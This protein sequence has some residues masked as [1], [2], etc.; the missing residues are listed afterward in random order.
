MSWG[1]RD[2]DQIVIQIT[3]N[4]LKQCDEHRTHKTGLLEME[5]GSRPVERTEKA[6]L[7]HFDRPSIQARAKEWPPPGKCKIRSS[8][9][10]RSTGCRIENSL[11]QAK[12]YKL[13]SNCTG[14]GETMALGMGV[15]IGARERSKW[16]RV[17]GFGGTEDVSF[18]I[19]TWLGYMWLD[20]ENT[21]LFSVVSNLCSSLNELL[22][23][24][25]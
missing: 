25:A 11:R 9:W 21:L 17:R 1:D 20:H 14:L 2:V 16:K 12:L 19:S 10:K 4:C 5:E 22:G 7:R 15:M 6:V 13:G 24:Q 23:G 18:F 8:H 3:G